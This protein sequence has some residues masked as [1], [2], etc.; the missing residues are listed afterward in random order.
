MSSYENYKTKISNLENYVD[1]SFNRRFRTIVG[2]IPPGSRVLDVACGSGTVMQALEAKGC[3]VRGIDIAPGAVALAK[4]KNLDVVL[5]DVDQFETDPAIREL[6]LA[7][8]DVIIFSK[9]LR[10]LSRKNALMKML[11]V[12]N[13]IVNQRNPSYWRAILARI[14][15]TIPLLDLED[16]PYVSAE[17]REIPH[18]SLSNFREWGESYG[19]K[20][21]VLLGNFLRSRDAVTLFYR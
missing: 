19:F 3:K 10:Y 17:G 1:A 20:S 4:A 14:R 21:K 7:D 11:K 18:T 6:I 5:G 2:A 8:Y 9:C 15:G 13:I 12:K 16:L